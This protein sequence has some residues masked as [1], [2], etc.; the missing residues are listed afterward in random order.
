M[1]DKMDRRL[2]RT[3]HMLSNPTL[4]TA[5]RR[6]NTT[7]DERLL[8]APDGQAGLDATH[9]DPCRVLRIMVAFRA[10]SDNLAPLTPA[11]PLFGSARGGPADP[12][13]HA[14]HRTV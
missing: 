2:K 5:A 14:S 13:Y 7:E 3:A 10:G 1:S 12:S 6:G 4:D 8:R 9:T 11:A